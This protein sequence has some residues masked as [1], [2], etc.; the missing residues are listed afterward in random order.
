MRIGQKVDEIVGEVEVIGL[1]ASPLM[2]LV[3]SMLGT[4]VNSIRGFGG[5]FVDVVFDPLKTIADNGM[6]ASVS[7]EFLNVV[8][9]TRRAEYSPIKPKV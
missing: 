1:R 4:L 3:T 2:G 9:D 7:E 5:E 6:P 8:Y